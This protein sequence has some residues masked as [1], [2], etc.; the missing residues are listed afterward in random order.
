MVSRFHSAEIHA[1]SGLHIDVAKLQLFFFCS[2]IRTDISLHNTEAIRK[3][4]S[5]HKIM[6]YIY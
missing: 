6:K 5:T 2:E 3:V 4:R 1:F